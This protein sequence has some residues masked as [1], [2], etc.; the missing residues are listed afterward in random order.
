MSTEV[1]PKQK[2]K[3][4]V[5]HFAETATTSCPVAPPPSA[6]HIKFSTTLVKSLKEH[7]LAL[8]IAGLNEQEDCSDSQNLLFSYHGLSL[9]KDKLVLVPYYI[10][11]NTIGVGADCTFK[12]S[13]L[14]DH[15]PLLIEYQKEGKEPNIRTFDSVAICLKTLQ[16][17]RQQYQIT[18]QA[19]VIRKESFC[20]VETF[21]DLMN[22]DS[23][24]AEYIGESVFKT[25]RL[26][27]SI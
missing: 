20:C 18:R 17:Y 13:C 12:L 26:Q 2:K 16:E 1:V 22:L 5:L 4:K 7:F 25:F 9:R 8:L 14:G 19:K 3:R 6:I 23:F 15:A 27:N 21:E 11:A 10:D 24:S